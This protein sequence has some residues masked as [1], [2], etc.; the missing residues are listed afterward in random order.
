MKSFV[1]LLTLAAL[2]FIPTVAQHPAGPDFRD[3][4]VKKD[5]IE[6]SSPVSSEILTPARKP[7]RE[8]GSD[9]MLSQKEKMKR[10]VMKS[11]TCPG[12]PHLLAGEPGRC[13]ECGTLLNR[14][15]KEKMK[16]EGAGTYA[17]PQHPEI[18]GARGSACTVC[19]KH[20]KVVKKTSHHHTS[21]VK[22]CVARD[23]SG[24]CRSCGDDR[25]RSPKEK[26][27]MDVMKMCCCPA[28]GG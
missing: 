11:Y 26:M 23:K 8:T 15:A 14:T 18:K 25:M 16:M 17:C 6:T 2:F 5:T 10:P 22:T 9:L 1:L 4:V 3:G 21:A 13:P 20:L 24:K 19:G 12:H 7:R 27:K 28:N